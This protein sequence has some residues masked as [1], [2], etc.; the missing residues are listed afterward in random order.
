MGTWTVSPE[1]F[2]KNDSAWKVSPEDFLGQPDTT[3][4]A[5]PKPVPGMEAFGGAPPAPPKA[6]LP[7]GLSAPEPIDQAPTPAKV[8][9]A[10]V[11]ILEKEP[12][13]PVP[14]GTP[15]GT[16]FVPSK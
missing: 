12:S 10:N 11:P 9:Q 8:K 16:V 1:D 5:K 6:P 14:A 15:A 2:L 7:E 13:R 4:R 3:Y